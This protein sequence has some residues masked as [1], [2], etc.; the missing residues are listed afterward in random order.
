MIITRCTEDDNC[1]IWYA[2][3]T[4]GTAWCTIS[5]IMRLVSHQDVRN[6]EL[7]RGAQKM[8]IVIYGML[9][10]HGVLRGA[11]YL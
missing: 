9:F 7:S 10:L 3:F 8:I 6:Y 5:L 11:P 4:R 1:N 2:V